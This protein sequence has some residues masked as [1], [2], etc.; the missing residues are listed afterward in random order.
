MIMCALKQCNLCFNFA[1]NKKEMI[2][3]S[4]QVGIPLIREVL[5]LQTNT[6]ER[7]SSSVV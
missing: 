4:L 5:R 1:Q 2:D 6:T 3:Q 7:S